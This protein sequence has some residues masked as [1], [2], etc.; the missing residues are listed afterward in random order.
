MTTFP[1]S[2]NDALCRLSNFIPKAGRNYAKFRNYDRGAGAHHDVS[3]LSPYIRRRIVSEKEVLKATLSHHSLSG[4][5][6]FVQEIFWRTY[7][8]GWLEMRP[9]VWTLYQED[10]GKLA[11]QLATQSG[12]RQ[13]WEVACLGQTG[14]ECFDAWARELTTTGYLHNHARMWFASIWIFTLKLP[15]Q[16]GADFFLR[17]LFDGDPA[18]NTLSWRWVAGLQTNGKTYLARSANISKYTSNRF[19]PTM[20]AGEGLPLKEPVTHERCFVPANINQDNWAKSLLLLHEEDV[21][22]SEVLGKF[23]NTRGA[24]RISRLHRLTPFEMSDQL[25]DFVEAVMANAEARWISSI[26]SIEIIGSVNEIIIA[27]HDLGVEQIV[28][29]YA[30]SGPVKSFLSQLAKKS[31]SEGLKIISVIS[32]YDRLCWPKATHGFFRFKENIPNFLS[33]LGL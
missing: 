28:T 7:W 1:P 30:P 24:F 33:R 18:S 17:H 16:L 21:D 32:E 29:P 10:V 31:K 5:Q 12:F 9:T 19:K 20:L 22:L 2:R 3:C 26:G 14:I 23:P 6:K 8:K 13:A 4:A 11:N 25:T 15:W 27:A